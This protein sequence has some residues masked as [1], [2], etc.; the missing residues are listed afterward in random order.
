MINSYQQTSTPTE[1]PVT[2]DE[3]KDMLE[4]NSTRHDSKINLLIAAATS[5]AE[6]F[7]GQVF[8]QRTMVFNLDKMYEKVKIPIH[9]VLSIENVKYRSGGNLETLETSKYEYDV[10]AFPPFVK[11]TDI[12]TIDDETNAV[13]INATLGYSQ[14]STIPADIKVAI[15]FFVFQ[16]FQNRGDNKD[17]IKKTFQ[18]ALYPY[19]LTQV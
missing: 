11:F 4:I 10:H 13:K 15:L 6:N 7:T 2:L 12:P 16:S 19:K 3:A 1:Y 8:V 17:Q 18:N 14:V 5:K 9:P